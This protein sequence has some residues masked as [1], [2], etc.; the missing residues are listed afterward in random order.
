[1]NTD[2]DHAV[3]EAHFMRTPLQLLVGA[4]WKRLVAFRVDSAGVLLGGSLAQYEKQTAFVPWEDITSLVVWQQRTAG[5]GLNHIGVHR[6]PGSPRLAGP[7]SRMTPE[8]AARTAP[9][10]EYELLLASRPISW[11]RL[12]PERLKV[13]TDTFAPGIPVL[14]YDRL[15]P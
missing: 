5:Q 13:A 11:W 14:A 7:N 10:V 1:M 12:A 9:H 8:Q 15:S 6:R 2:H 4:G 3:Y